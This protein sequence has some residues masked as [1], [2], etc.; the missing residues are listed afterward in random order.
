MTQKQMILRYMEDHGS[1][2]T[3]EAYNDLGIT[4]LA[5]RISEMITD[6]HRIAKETETSFNRFG[7]KV[8]Y[9]RYRKAM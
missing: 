1:I 2:S 5:A 9:T 3:M 8:S 4:R 7:D 6:G